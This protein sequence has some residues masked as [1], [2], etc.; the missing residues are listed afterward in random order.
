[1]RSWYVILGCVLLA[2]GSGVLVGCKPDPAF[3]PNEQGQTAAGNAL[4]STGT[5]WGLLLGTAVNIVASVFISKG[6]VEKKDKEDYNNDDV[7][8]MMRRAS[9]LGYV[10][11]RKPTA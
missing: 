8:S 5:P 3:T 9:E 7:D 6:A 1:M 2:V 4:V 11:S 10:V